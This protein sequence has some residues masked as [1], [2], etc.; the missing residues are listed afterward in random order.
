MR[1]PTWQPLTPPIARRLAFAKYLVQLA[2]RELKS[3]TDLA[4]S[5]AV[6][7]YHDALELL[8]ISILDAHKVSFKKETPFLGFVDIIRKQRGGFVSEHAASQLVGLRNLLT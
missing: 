4:A 5:V 1:D 7:H 8:F 2:R 3:N 6:L